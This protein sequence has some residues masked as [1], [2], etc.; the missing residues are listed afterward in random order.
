MRNIGKKYLLACYTKQTAALYRAE[1]G[2][3]SNP[4][5]EESQGRREFE[6]G[7]FSTVESL[8]NFAGIEKFVLSA[9]R[10]NEWA[11]A[12]RVATTPAV[13]DSD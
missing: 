4:F 5:S 13:G 1:E 2:C 7:A 6:R 3:L 10:Q 11:T 8:A 9:I 12:R